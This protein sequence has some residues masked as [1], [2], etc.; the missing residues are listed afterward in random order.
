MVHWL[1]NNLYELQKLFNVEGDGSMVI[2][3]EVKELVKRHQY[4]RTLSRRPHGTHRPMYYTDIRVE[5]LAKDH[6]PICR[7]SSAAG[8]FMWFK[9]G[10]SGRLFEL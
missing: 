2:N 1:F 3:G 10:N 7:P 4:F 6:R 8:G 9:A 5:L